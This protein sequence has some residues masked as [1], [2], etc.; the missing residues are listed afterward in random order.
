MILTD[1]DFIYELACGSTMRLKKQGRSIF[2]LNARFAP[3]AVPE[4]DASIRECASNAPAL[5]RFAVSV[6]TAA[7]R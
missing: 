4:N 1:E 2:S 7:F 3:N 5:L 6:E